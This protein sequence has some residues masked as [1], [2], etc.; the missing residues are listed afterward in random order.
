MVVHYKRHCELAVFEVCNLEKTNLIIDHTWLKRHNPTIDWITGEVT[1][2]KYSR[3]YGMCQ[4]R[5]NKTKWGEHLVEGIIEK[6]LE[7][8]EE[9]YRLIKSL[10]VEEKTTKKLPRELGITGTSLSLRKKL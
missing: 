4:V 1:L 9:V 6:D 10:K 8:V 7:S 2:N 3:D 5:F